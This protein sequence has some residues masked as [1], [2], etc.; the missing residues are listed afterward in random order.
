MDPD[1]RQEVLA[2]PPSVAEVFQQTEW[3][4]TNEEESDIITVEGLS[5]WFNA[6]ITYFTVELQS[7]IRQMSDSLQ[8]HNKQTTTVTQLTEEYQQ[9]FQLEQKKSISVV[10][11]S[12]T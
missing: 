10:L 11:R 8:W 1:N 12:F 3:K 4:T 5:G 7:C 9:G 6:V 2:S